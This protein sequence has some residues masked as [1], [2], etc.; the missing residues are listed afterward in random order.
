MNFNATKHDIL[1]D[2]ARIFDLLGVIGRYPYK[3]TI[4]NGVA[5]SRRMERRDFRR[6]STTKENIKNKFN[7]IKRA[8]YTRT[9]INH[10][11]MIK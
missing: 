5:V 6:D 2:I 9:T 7:I 8:N 10:L 1:T 4:T 11:L 3:V